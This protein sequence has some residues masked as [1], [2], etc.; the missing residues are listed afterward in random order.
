[1]SKV[2]I[3]L[4]ERYNLLANENGASEIL[5]V[6]STVDKALNKL[7]NDIEINVNEYNYV[8]D[9]D[10][11]LEKFKKDKVGYVTLFYGVQENWDYYC[12]YRIIEKEMN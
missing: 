2:Y 8:I 5:G 7:L 9:T 10:C 3:A 1:M 12:E 11:D 4:E 6:Y